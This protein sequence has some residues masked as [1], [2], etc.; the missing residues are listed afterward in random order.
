MCV[1]LFIVKHNLLPVNTTIILVIMDD[2]LKIPQG[3]LMKFA[4]LDISS[5]YSNIP[6]GEMTKILNDLCVKGN[7][8]DKT[9]N[10]IVKITQIIVNQNYFRFQDNI[11]QQNEGLAM[12]SPT[13]SILSEV[14]EV[15]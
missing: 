5:M 13:S 6:T 1:N 12:G 9:R 7:V 11:Y 14:Y 4:S 8:D 3:H 10:E 15:C 2:P